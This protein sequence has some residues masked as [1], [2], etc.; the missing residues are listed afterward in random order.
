MDDKNYD[1]FY[2]FVKLNFIIIVHAIR[3]RILKTILE[4]G[5]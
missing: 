5:V 1:Y 2:F 3:C 4:I